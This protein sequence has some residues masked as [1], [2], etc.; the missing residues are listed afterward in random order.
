[1]EE[2]ENEIEMEVEGIESKELGVMVF[3]SGNGIGMLGD[4]SEVVDNGK[5]K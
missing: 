4:D 1:M 2:L 5:I 3:V